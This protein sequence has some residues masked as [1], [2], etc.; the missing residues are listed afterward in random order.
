[1]PDTDPRG[2]PSPIPTGLLCRCP[3]CGKG[4]LFSGFLTLAPR[5]EVCGLDTRFADTGDGPSFFAS[6]LGGFLTLL[7]GVYA[8]IVYSPDWWVYAL[9]LIVGMVAT[10]LMIRPMK[11]VLVALQY[12][13]KAEQGRFEPT[14]P[15]P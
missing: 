9:L 8:Q 10:V 12:A 7:V 5:C 11:G 6:F 2:A 1:M 15:E 13:N 4:A 3:R 14:R